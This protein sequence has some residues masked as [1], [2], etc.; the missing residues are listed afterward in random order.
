MIIKIIDLNQ[1]S[2]P[3]SDSLKSQ[4]ATI[5]L[6]WFVLLLTNVM[7]FYILKFGFLLTTIKT[8]VH[9]FTPNYYLNC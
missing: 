2:N 9:Y 5:F 7:F 1:Q 6:N 8:A 3:G 4:H